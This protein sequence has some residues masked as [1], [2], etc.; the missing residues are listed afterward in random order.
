[1]AD[2]INITMADGYYSPSTVL[3]LL[4]E[5]LTI[6]QAALLLLNV[7][8]E[9]Y[10]LAEYPNSERDAPV[11]YE[12]ARQVLASALMAN[13]VEGR[14]EWKT[15]TGVDYNSNEAYE[16][17]L[18]G[19]LCADK[20]TINMESLKAWL[21]SKNVTVEQFA[22]L[23]DTSDDFLNR[24]DPTYSPKLAAAV[25][26]WRHVR[27]NSVN[28]ISIKQQL[29][30]W[31]RDNSHR[32]WPDGIKPKVTDTYIKEAARL[33]NWAS[34]GG[35]PSIIEENSEKNSASYAPK[36]SLLQ[37]TYGQGGSQRFNIDLDEEIPF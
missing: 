27:N 10:P 19:N 14:K 24:D 7:D 18:E 21:A 33:A 9:H 15:Q 17:V 1:M 32:Y 28:G 16:D 35:R 11:G 4:A 37:K 5:E 12:A 23:S 29:K 25:A 6:R 20:A 8:P 30:N 13:K 22:G 36:K 3:W 31:L 34:E 26:A 2:N